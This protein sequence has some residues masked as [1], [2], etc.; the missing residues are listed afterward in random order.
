MH[1]GDISARVLRCVSTSGG[2]SKKLATEASG[3]E[4]TLQCSCL[5]VSSALLTTLGGIIRFVESLSYIPH[6]YLF[7]VF[8]LLASRDILILCVCSRQFYFY[9][10]LCFWDLFK[11]PCEYKYL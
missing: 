7:I 10:A 11:I 5:Q 6:R 8:V 4:G 9:C 1:S 2:D 3:E